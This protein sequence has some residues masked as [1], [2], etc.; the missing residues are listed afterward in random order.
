MKFWQAMPDVPRVRKDTLPDSYP[1][2]R[3]DGCKVGGPSCVDCQLNV[4]KYDAPEMALEERRDRIDARDA[5]TVRLY[6]RGWGVNRIARHLH[7]STRSIHRA[8]QRE[9]DG[10]LDGY[11]SQ[12]PQPAILARLEALK[13]PGALFRAS[14]KG[15]P[16]L[17]APGRG[18][19]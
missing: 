10:E 11:R 12:S 7:V 8:V 13:D 16:S 19:G 4:C 18:R 2:Y 14:W 5:E 9:R 15:L 1:L 17:L 6:A 3:D